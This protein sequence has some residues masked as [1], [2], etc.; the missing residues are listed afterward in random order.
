VLIEFL[1]EPIKVDKKEFAKDLR[2][3]IT[4]QKQMRL[5][6]TFYDPKNEGGFIPLDL[7][8]YSID[9]P[10]IDG[11]GLSFGLNGKEMGRNIP[12]KLKLHLDII[13]RKWKL[14]GCFNNKDLN[15]TMNDISEVVTCIR[16]LL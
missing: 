4:E 6:I 1:N 9:T 11:L 13:K 12:F 15:K 2:I 16:D 3:N 7:V 10:R 8:V 14:T 5:K